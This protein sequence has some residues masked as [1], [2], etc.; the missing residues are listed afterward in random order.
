MRKGIF[1][2][3]ITFIVIGLVFVPCSNAASE[4]KLVIAIGQEPTSVDQ[5]LIYLGADYIAVM[6]WGERLIERSPSGDLVPGLA[7]SWKFSADGKTME[8]TLRKGV[9]FHSG[10]PLTA[11]DVKFSYERAMTKNKSMPIFLRLVE[12][13]E[14]IDDYRFKIHFKEPDVLFVPM[15]G[16]AS[17]VSKSYYD[18]V[19]E[20]KFTHQPVG[21][22]AYK[23]VKYVPGEYIDVERF[24]DYWGGKPSVDK[25]RFLFVPEDLTR[26]S[27]LKAGEVDLLGSIPYS[28]I[29][30]LQKMPGIKLLRGEA[31]HPTPT[32]QFNTLNPKV[33]WYDRRVRLAMAY[34]INYDAIIKDLLL[35]IP[36]HYAC[37][38][39]WEIGYDPNLKPY[40]YN[41]KRAR[42]LLTEAGYPNG[43]E[44]PF[45]Y[46][47]TGT[48]PMINQT[49][50]TIAAYF[51]AVG[52]RAE[53][54]GE[55]AA[56][57][58]ARRRAAK[59][60]EGHNV[61]YVGL[62]SRGAMAGGVHPLQ[63]LDAMFGTNRSFS[64]YSNPEF[65]KYMSEARTA[66]NDLK[67]QNEAI[68]QGAKILHDDVAGI[69]LYN[70]VPIYAM[71]KNIDFLPQI[72]YPFEVLLV[73]NMSVK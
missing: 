23:F 11:K 48:V 72:R 14:I 36:A 63:F 7:T 29:R 41:P 2:S 34:A 69:P 32:I 59:A 53:I 30:D 21:T 40:T 56:A 3:I 28:L 18:R 64:P 54:H 67:E 65:D 66:I 20:D 55:E 37:L 25:A 46:L 8:F 13:F 45:Y 68:R 31:G 35:G 51:K 33:P 19:G 61:V 15:Q 52:I 22:G 44:F 6:N 10:D 70:Y 42:E 71:K 9:K 73:K 62:D 58:S 24:D 27:K 47:I 43:F 60:S 26:I 17:I 4:N 39:P 57:F 50:E 49:A 1:G 38:A 5:S 16:I 12:S